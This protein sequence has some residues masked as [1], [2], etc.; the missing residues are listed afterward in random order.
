MPGLF[1]ALPLLFAQEG[2]PAP[3]AGAGQTPGLIT[4]LPYV[5]IIGLWF[6][7]LLSARSRSKTSSAAR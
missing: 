4:F 6:Y 1:D 7:L 2:A 5:A 3:A